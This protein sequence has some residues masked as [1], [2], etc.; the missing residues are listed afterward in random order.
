METSTIMVIIWM[1][2]AMITA[3]FIQIPNWVYSALLVL[4][5]LLIYFVIEIELRS[6]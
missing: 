1:L 5:L 3:I 2:F 4:V 6:K